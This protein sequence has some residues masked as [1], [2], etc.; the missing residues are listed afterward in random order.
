MRILEENRASQR[1]LQLF[2]W[3]AMAGYQIRFNFKKKPAA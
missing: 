3:A 1:L 2:K